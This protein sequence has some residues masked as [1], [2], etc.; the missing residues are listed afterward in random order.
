M[1]VKIKINFL[2]MEISNKFLLYDR[3]MIKDDNNVDI[4]RL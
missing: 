2:I 3:Y 1:N 4:I